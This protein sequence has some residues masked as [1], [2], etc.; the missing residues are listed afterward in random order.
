MKGRERFERAKTRST[1]DVEW[2]ERGFHR[3]LLNFTWRVNRKDLSGNNVF[4]DG[5]LGL[6]IIGVFDCSG[7]LPTG[8]HL[9]QAD[10]TAWM[11]LY[12]QNMPRSPG[13]LPRNAQRTCRCATNSPSISCGLRQR[14]SAPAATPGTWDEEDGFFY[15]VLRMPDGRYQRL[16]VRSMVGLPPLSAVTVF[17]GNLMWKDPVLTRRLQRFLDERPPLRAFM[18]DPLKVGCCG[19]MLTAILDER[20]L[21]RVLSTML[22]EDAFL[23]PH[24]IRAPCLWLDLLQSGHHALAFT[25]CP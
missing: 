4:E 10:G 5:F 12:C 15:D 19:S 21:R 6:E 25:A 14:W 8:G 22:D 23:G 2:I 18:H 13:S 7:P 17:E 11:A 1:G 20:R 9:E 3:L 24:G 16:R